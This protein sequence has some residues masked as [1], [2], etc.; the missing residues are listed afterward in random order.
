MASNDLFT[1]QR[2]SDH[3]F[4]ILIN[5]TYPVQ[6]WRR[7]WIPRLLDVDRI[8]YGLED[9][10][11]N[12]KVSAISFMVADTDRKIW[13]TYYGSTGTF[14]LNSTVQLQLALGTENDL[15][16]YHNLFT[17]RIT[18]F[19]TSQAQITF[20]CENAIRSLAD[21]YFIWDYHNI[22]HHEGGGSLGFVSAVNGSLVYYDDSE[23]DTIKEY[24]GTVTGRGGAESHYKEIN[25]LRRY[26]SLIKG[27]QIESG[28]HIGDVLKFSGSNLTTDAD[29]GSILFNISSYTVRF[30]TVV[31]RVGTLEL[32]QAPTD[33]FL[34]HK[35]YR[36]VDLFYS[37]N[38]ADIIWDILTGSNTTIGFDSQKNSNN[39]DI[40]YNTW[41]KSRNALLPITC[42]K[43]IEPKSD[44][45]NKAVD[46][47]KELLE[48]TLGFLWFD[49]SG[50]LFYKTFGPQDVTQSVGSNYQ[51]GTLNNRIIGDDFEYS[52][53]WE[54]VANQINFYY[55]YF[56]ELEQDSKF[57]AYYTTK[58]LTAAGRFGSSEKSRDY[59]N[60]WLHNDNFAVVTA[61]RYLAKHKYGMPFIRFTT[62]L[63]ALELN[64]ATVIQ[65]THPEGKL[66]NRKFFL[67]EKEVAPLDGQI[68]LSGWDFGAV[69]GT[70]GYCFWE[71]GTSIGSTFGDWWDT[72]FS[73]RKKIGCGNHDRYGTVHYIGVQLNTEIIDVAKSNGSDIRVVLQTAGSK[74][75]L[76]RKFMR[77]GGTIAADTWVWF[78]V[79]PGGQ[80]DG[81]IS[82]NEDIGAQSDYAYY[83]YYDNSL[84]TAPAPQYSNVSCIDSPYT[85]DGNTLSLLDFFNTTGSYHS[86]T[87]SNHGSFVGVDVRDG[88]NDN[89]GGGNA[90]VFNN[91]TND[92]ILL[93]TNTA[94][95]KDN[96][97][98]AE[99]WFK[100]TATAA[101]APN[102]DDIY[103]ND[104]YGLCRIEAS[105]T[106][107]IYANDGA[108]K[109]KSYARVNDGL[110]H[111]VALIKQASTKLELWT[112][113]TNRGSVS[114][115][116]QN[117]SA[118]RRPTIGAY[119]AD[120][121][122]R[123]FQGTI[124]GFRYS[125]SIRGT[126][127]H[128]NATL[129]ATL[130]ASDNY[131]LALAV[132]GTSRAGWG[133]GTV[134]NLDSR[135]GE[136]CR[137]W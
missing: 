62:A 77:R 78:Q 28:I 63:N 29:G 19:K 73:Q 20:G 91:G 45:K 76:G 96:D 15:T 95:L 99:A 71:D 57:L 100:T 127:Y 27:G 114:F 104:F 111:H 82:S 137:W 52:S 118:S 25:F 3:Y 124:W 17:G 113:G 103:E 98:T 125:N 106:V 31:N 24:F 7:G 84:A 132:S 64:L 43:L 70:R 112:D 122:T 135:I 55:D 81:S 26:H 85:T 51:F 6:D 75:E 38:P 102:S 33:V 46:E 92:Y 86:E 48:T 123:N 53:N 130:S 41:N 115:G 10:T 49:Q 40:D 65:V 93:G 47:L 56:P 69:F 134:H 11:G 1:K 34:N 110:A 5:G 23:A 80:P 108:W 109:S 36:R 79:H 37:G 67:T 131:G 74:Y 22:T 2:W 4:R 136:T 59:F 32:N 94:S 21:A 101:A 128:V 30:G 42:Y 9:W 50:K 12:L 18:E 97:V 87:G 120:P 121:I 89:F 72:S 61:G 13:D 54:D 60:K 107:Y 39:A 129:T 88:A 105:G 58:D 14:P 116:A 126:F 66:Q 83:I 68:V 16:D 8:T 117:T 133:N 35:I 90:P 44:E 119:S